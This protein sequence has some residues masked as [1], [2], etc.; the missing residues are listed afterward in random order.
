MKSL[1]LLLASTSAALGALP[2]VG[3][4]YARP[5]AAVPA[6]FR[7]A[8]QTLA[9]KTAEPADAFARGEWWQLFSDTALN[10]LETRALSANQDLR[11][12]AARVEQARA[13]AGIARGSYW[14]DV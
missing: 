13:A 1:Y 7:D 9:W 12:A 2:A 3:P 4:N 6:E 5:S 14:P 10:D 11:G 8:D